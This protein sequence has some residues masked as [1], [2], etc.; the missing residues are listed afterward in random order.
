MEFGGVEFARLKEGKTD[1]VVF[2]HL[3]DHENPAEWQAR[4]GLR[5]A[6]KRA[7]LFIFQITDAQ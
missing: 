3:E 1:I 7:G 6:A 2:E 4:M 5:Q